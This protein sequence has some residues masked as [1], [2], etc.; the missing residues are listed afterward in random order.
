[1]EKQ[2]VLSPEIRAKMVKIRELRNKKEELK[3]SLEQIEAELAVLNNEVTDFFEAH[4]IQNI[5][6]KDIGNFYLNR[7]LFPQIEDP[8]KCH[9]WLKEKGDFESLLSFNTNK[10]KSYYKEK[11]ELG[12]ELPEGV[13]Q[14]FKVEVRVRKA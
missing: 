10:F 11:M 7:S 1:M 14:F 9:Q 5:T 12:E 4:R 6:I 2:E 8:V 3:I 13:T